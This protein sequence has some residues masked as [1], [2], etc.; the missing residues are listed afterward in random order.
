[1]Q[2]LELTIAKLFLLLTSSSVFTMQKAK[3]ILGATGL[4][5]TMKRFILVKI[6]ENTLRLENVYPWYIQ[7]RSFGSLQL[8][9]VAL[10]TVNAIAP[11][12]DH[13][14]RIVVLELVHS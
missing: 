3:V 11:Y 6:Y 8:S 1:M 13:A 5:K 7:G 4:L 10:N 14:L 12:R 2:S 9:L